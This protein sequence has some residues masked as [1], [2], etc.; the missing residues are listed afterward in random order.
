MN[1]QSVDDFS[2]S[3]NSLLITNIAIWHK[4]TLVRSGADIPLDKKARLFLDARVLNSERNNLRDT[5]DTL[6]GCI[7]YSTKINYYGEKK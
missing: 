6:V 4:D 5:I 1:N 7:N 3:I 2:T